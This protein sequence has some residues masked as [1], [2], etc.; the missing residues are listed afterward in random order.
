MSIPTHR[1]RT[2]CRSGLL[3]ALLATSVVQATEA[4]GPDE[5]RQI[6]E[7]CHVEAEAAGLKGTA[8]EE[9]V[10]QCVAELLAV[11]L[12]NLARD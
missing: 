1:N 5:M 9:F 3:L 10:D 6:R 7:D 4:P 12:Y 8:L 11:E 2:R